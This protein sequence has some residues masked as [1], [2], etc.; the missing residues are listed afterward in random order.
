MFYHYTNR[1]K[2]SLHLHFCDVLFMIR[3]R[4]CLG[5]SRNEE[6]T[7][8]VHP[9]YSSRSR[10]THYQLVTLVSRHL[11]S[12]HAASLYL[13]LLFSFVHTLLPECPIGGTGLAWLSPISWRN[14]KPYSTSN[15]W[16][17]NICHSPS[18][19]SI[20]SFIFIGID[21]CIFLLYLVLCLNTVFHFLAPFFQ[22]YLWEALLVCLFW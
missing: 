12:V 17:R 14:I 22:L 11:Q 20:Y 18:P 3:L 5:R 1:E 21:A 4:F 8:V 16:V 13:M 9:P 2:K 19:L 15:S 6:H 10:G 7:A